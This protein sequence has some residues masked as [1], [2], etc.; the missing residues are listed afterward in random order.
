MGCV[1]G[2]GVYFGFMVFSKVM[3]M[4]SWAIYQNENWFS[5]KNM[6]SYRDVNKDFQ[7]Q[8]NAADT[9]MGKLYCQRVYAAA[10]MIRTK[11]HDIFLLTASSCC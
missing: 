4:K 3:K 6:K 5:K 9:I 11:H 1:C 8:I 2:S 10:L 7:Y